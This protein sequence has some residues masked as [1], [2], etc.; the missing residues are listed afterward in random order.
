MFVFLTVK[1][2]QKEKQKVIRLLIDLQ[3]V[4]VTPK[5]LKIPMENLK[6]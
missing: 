4:K 3:M 1:P 5:R 6:R 2:K